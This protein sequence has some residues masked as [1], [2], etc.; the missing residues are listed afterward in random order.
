MTNNYKGKFISM[1]GCE[2]VG[3]TTQTNKLKKYLE[4]NGYDILFI[5]EPGGTKI[6][7]EIRKILLCKDSANMDPIVETTLYMAARKQLIEEKIIPALKEGKIVLCDRF[8]DSTF[9]YQAIARNIGQEKILEMHKIICDNVF[10]DITIFLDLN[11]QDAFKRKGGADKNDR[12]EQQGL[13]F[14]NQVY[15]GYKIAKQLFKNRI[16]EVDSKGKEEEI[17]ENIL[18]ILRENNICN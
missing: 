16:Y 18:K 13:E 17:F 15:N 10:P 11:P 5:R 4:E 1:E 8:F 7:E 9:A 3:K 12:M 2:G 14:H 6:S